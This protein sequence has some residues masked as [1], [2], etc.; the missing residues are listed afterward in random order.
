VDALGELPNVVHDDLEWH[1]DL[2]ERLGQRLPAPV[3]LPKVW[4]RC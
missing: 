4:I 1:P 3:I 2:L